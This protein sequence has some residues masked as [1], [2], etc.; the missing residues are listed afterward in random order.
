MSDYI[1]TAENYLVDNFQRLNEDF[2]E[3]S[4]GRLVEKAKDLL[5]TDANNSSEYYDIE[6]FLPAVSPANKLPQQYP[7]YLPYDYSK[8]TPGNYF[9]HDT[10]YEHTSKTPSDGVVDNI[11]K[12]GLA[13]RHHPGM[14]SS[15]G[16]EYIEPTAWNNEVSKDQLGNYKK[17]KAL[18][19][20]I[21]AHGSAYE[22]AGRSP[23]VGTSEG[24]KTLPE[25]SRTTSLSKNPVV[26][27]KG[28][29]NMMHEM[30]PDF[31]KL[32]PSQKALEPHVN[33]T[34][35]AGY[36]DKNKIV[37][38]FPKG[39]DELMVKRPVGMFTGKVPTFGSIGANLVDMFM[40]SPDYQRAKE[41]PTFGMGEAERKRLDAA[42][43]YGL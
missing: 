38:F 8:M 37:G 4:Q 35:P 2:K 24:V 36:I 32:T 31:K 29:P 3:T 5:S 16:V 1:Q 11:Y 6:P 13:G 21:G 17:N 40:M 30:G 18:M 19:Q 33:G 12:K 25:G 7:K 26:V 28:E 41:D 39:S 10:G 27:L 23:F 15:G 43:E 22:K 34:K 14:S 42:Y 9:V 20:R